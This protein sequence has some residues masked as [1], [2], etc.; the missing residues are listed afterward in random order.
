LPR[1]DALVMPTTPIVAPTIAEVADPKVF[2]ARNFMLLRNTAIGNFF[3]L[4]A[5]SL[6]LNAALA[7]RAHAP[8]A[9]RPGSHA[10]AHCRGNGRAF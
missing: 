2:A 4:C 1:T 3:D 9:Q 6:P 7:G 5:I 8:R 10:A